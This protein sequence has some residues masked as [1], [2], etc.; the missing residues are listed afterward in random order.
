MTLGPSTVTLRHTIAAYC[1]HL[2]PK[3]TQNK[4][5]H[6]QKQADWTADTLQGHATLTEAPPLHFSVIPTAQNNLWSAGKR[7]V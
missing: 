5:H 2:D 7:W 6:K 1:Q 3:R 4:K